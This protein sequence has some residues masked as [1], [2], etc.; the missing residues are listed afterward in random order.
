MVQKAL[1]KITL[2]QISLGSEYLQ[3]IFYI[4]NILL[5]DA[6]DYSLIIIFLNIRYYSN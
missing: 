2:L 1:S 6:Y 5:K 3:S 4:M